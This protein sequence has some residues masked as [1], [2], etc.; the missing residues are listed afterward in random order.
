MSERKRWTPPPVTTPE[1]REDQ[2]IVLAIDLAE[3]Q[4]RE[5]V[6]STPVIT[7]YLKLG[8]EREKL[9]REK[10]R[11]ENEALKAKTEQLMSSQRSEEAY[12]KVM[13]AFAKYS[14]HH[15]EEVDDDY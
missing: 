8:T 12:N 10:L 5:G 7:H 1:A 15:I 2:M 9:E 4:L 13:E 6:A 3:Q 11:A 14:G